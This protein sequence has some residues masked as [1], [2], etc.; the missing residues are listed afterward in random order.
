MEPLTTA[1]GFT[2]GKAVFKAWLKE[3]EFASTAADG[4]VDY[5]KSFVGDRRAR[6]A[7]E[8]HISKIADSAAD[9]LESYISF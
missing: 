1:L 7:A 6:G 5:L 8:R 3:N 9:A 2:I 4:A